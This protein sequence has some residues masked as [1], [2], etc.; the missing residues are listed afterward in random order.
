[1]SAVSVCQCLRL[2]R[3]CL[4]VRSLCL[5]PPGGWPAQVRPEANSNIQI[6]E[7]NLDE[8]STKDKYFVFVAFDS[9]P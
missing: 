7:K 8:M 4:N 2:V 6:I 3:D 1:M 9:Q 5:S